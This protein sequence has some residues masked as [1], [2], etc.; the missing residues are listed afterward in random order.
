MK[1]TSKKE[2][3]KKPTKKTAKKPLVK[4]KSEPKNRKRLSKFVQVNMATMTSVDSQTYLPVT[5][6]HIHG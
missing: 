4:V 1:K 2:A 3:L 5:I 6:R